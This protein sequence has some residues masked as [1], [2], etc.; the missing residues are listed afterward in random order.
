MIGSTPW[1]YKWGCGKWRVL[2]N[3]T[4]PNDAIS[5][6][7][8]SWVMRG[9]AYRGH[10]N[11]IKNIA[12]LILLRESWLFSLLARTS[13][14]T[15]CRSRLYQTFYFFVLSI[16]LVGLNFFI[17]IAKPRLIHHFIS[18]PLSLHDYHSGTQLEP[19]FYWPDCVIFF[20]SFFLFLMFF[21]YP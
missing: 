13:H 20:L 14:G 7:T 19:L 2:V 8:L 9:T 3:T 10:A 6:I 5:K 18:L 4:E 16:L 17:T 15:A 12:L 1:W 11:S 21:S